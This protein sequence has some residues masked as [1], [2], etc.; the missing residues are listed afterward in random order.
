M[1]GMRVAAARAFMGLSISKT[2][3]AAAQQMSGAELPVLRARVIG[4]IKRKAT[5][6]KLRRGLPMG[7]ARVHA[8]AKVLLLPLA[9]AALAAVSLSGQKPAPPQLE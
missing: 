4:G 5:H 9:A 2:F 8:D 7:V 3:R 1:V 6:G